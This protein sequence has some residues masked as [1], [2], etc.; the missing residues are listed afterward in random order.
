M[1]LMD[2]HVQ[3]F[4]K[5]A[6]LNLENNPLAGTVPSELGRLVALGKGPVCAGWLVC[7]SHVFVCSL[8]F[9]AE[10]LHAYNNTLSGAVPEQ[11]CNLSLLQEI[12]F[13]CDLA[14]TCCGGFCF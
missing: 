9:C 5:T 3:F 4:V 12:K 2:G 14:C 13:D 10:T 11:L 7:D 6:S 1:T 8:F